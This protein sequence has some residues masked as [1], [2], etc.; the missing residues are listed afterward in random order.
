MSMGVNKHWKLYLD[1]GAGTDDVLMSIKGVEAKDYPHA[2]LVSSNRRFADWLDRWDYEELRLAG[3]TISGGK[4]KKVLVRKME[5]GLKVVATSDAAKSFS[6]KFSR[7]KEWG[8]EVVSDLEEFDLWLDELKLYEKFELAAQNGLE[9]DNL[10]GV[11]V[12]AQDHGA[13]P[14]DV[15]D[16]R[17]RFD[18]F[19]SF[20]VGKK[21]ADV[22]KVIAEVV[23]GNFR[24]TRAMSILRQLDA[25]LAPGVEKSWYDTSLMACIGA[26]W[27]FDGRRIAVNFG[28]GHTI[29][30]AFEDDVIVGIYEHHTKK[31]LA[32]DGKLFMGQFSR[33]I[34]GE[35]E[36]NEVFDTRGHGVCYADKYDMSG[37]E[38]ILTG[39]NWRKAWEFLK[40]NWEDFGFG[41]VLLKVA[42]AFG[43]EFLT[44]IAGAMILER[45]DWDGDKVDVRQYHLS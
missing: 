35:L 2:V 18:E 28:N 41:S 45:G 44:G 17:W 23:D 39:P 6:D 3:N 29:A 4:F 43:S 33:F 25:E 16:R 38:V 5:K 26:A 8:I 34:S 7:L 11:V 24:P 15:S 36:F 14:E 12:L 10:V 9:V 21:V 1:L 20:C 40:S 30:V 31:V 32:E 37:V 42:V 13:A 19:L 27:P 22:R